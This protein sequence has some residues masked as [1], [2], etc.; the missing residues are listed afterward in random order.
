VKN[1]ERPCRNS[2]AYHLL[3]R[4]VGAIRISPAGKGT[5]PTSRG[6]SSSI[7]AL[8]RPR[9]RADRRRRPRRQYSK[10]Q[11]LG[12]NVIRTP[13]RLRRTALPGPAAGG[14]QFRHVD[15]HPS[16]RLRRVLHLVGRSD[17]QSTGM[18]GEA[19]GAW[20]IRG[21]GRVSAEYRAGVLVIEP[22][23][24]R[25]HYRNGDLSSVARV[26]PYARSWN[27]QEVRRHR[28]GTKL[29]VGTQRC[30][31]D[32]SAWRSAAS[33]LRLLGSGAVSFRYAS[34]R[35]ELVKK[36]HRGHE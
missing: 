1:P 4:R 19:N 17:R 6:R 29:V 27:A 22:C 8:D 35:Y 3:V 21:A 26:R 2:L 31:P 15:P 30:R 5:R 13:Q 14:L 11:S 33:G 20:A 28:I 23:R 10:S 16:R 9:R 7:T 25:S 34:V 12:T 18:L 32:S 24:M 36:S